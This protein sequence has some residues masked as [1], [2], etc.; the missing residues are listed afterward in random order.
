MSLA[1]KAANLG[2]WEWELGN[3]EIWT[4]DKGRSVLG[5]APDESV[6]Y[7]GLTMRV[8]PEDRQAREAAIRRAL[9]THGEY[10]IEY[11]VVLPDGRLRWIGSRGR[12]V[13]GDHKTTRLIGVSMDV[14]G[15]KQAQDALRESEA[16][17]RAMADTAPVMI[18]M[19]GT[20]KLCTFFN[21]GWLSFTGGPLEQE[22]GNGWA[23][24]VHQEDLDR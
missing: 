21:K 3:D 9:K 24:G 17:F 6:D 12:C 19:S 11:R 10:D 23:K 1:A 18:W 22:I 16:R 14:T 15:E 13:D 5:F 20:D 2:V 4:T 7:A 8:H